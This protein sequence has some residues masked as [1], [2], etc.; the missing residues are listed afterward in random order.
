MNVAH[1]V[2]IIVIRFLFFTRLNMLHR[3]NIANDI[4]IIYVQT[5]ARKKRTNQN[6]KY[7]SLR[8]N[9]I[10]QFYRINLHQLAFCCNH[11]RTYLVWL[12]VA[13]LPTIAIHMLCIKSIFN[14]VCCWKLISNDANIH[15][16]CP[17]AEVSSRKSAYQITGYIPFS[18]TAMSQNRALKKH[19]N[20]KK[21][22]FFK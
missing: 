3:L 10:Y 21:K 12:H 15:T 11:V 2:F 18:K 1:V 9:Q 20:I 16:P 19:L 7:L 8:S 13:N 4:F 22:H 5:R 6:R 17:C 14:R